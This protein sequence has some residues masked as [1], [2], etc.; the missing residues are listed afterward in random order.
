MHPNTPIVS[1]SDLQGGDIPTSSVY[2]IKYFSDATAFSGPSTVWS[3]R[4]DFLRCQVYNGNIYFHTQRGQDQTVYTGQGLGAMYIIDAVQGRVSQSGTPSPAI[5]FVSGES[6]SLG[7]R[8]SVIARLHSL[9][10]RR[11]A[12]L[13]SVL[14]CLNPCQ[15]APSQ[16]TSWTLTSR[17]TRRSGWLL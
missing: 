17:T 11:R 14:C 2:G 6:Q 5:D 1:S 9:L 4:N 7:N 13:S 3:G 8:L 10:L 12:A 16:T 15:P